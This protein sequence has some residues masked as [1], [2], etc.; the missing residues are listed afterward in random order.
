MLRADKDRRTQISSK[1]NENDLNKL[2]DAAGDPDRTVRIYATEF[3][4]DLG[5]KRATKLAIP[6][7]AKTN[8]DDARYNWLLLSQEGW[9]MLTQAEIDELEGP[10]KEAYERS[11]PKTKKLF[12]KLPRKK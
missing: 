8:D 10:Y 2:L 4:F 7:A 11:G 9:S 3:L 6:R 12:D 5:D 1:L